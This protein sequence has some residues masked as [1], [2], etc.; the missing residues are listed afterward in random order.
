MR[1]GATIIGPGNVGT[2][3]AMKLMKEGLPYEMVFNSYDSYVNAA[4]N[5][6][7]TDHI[8]KMGN[9]SFHYDYIIISVQDNLIEKAAKLLVEKR[10]N[11]IKDKIIFHTSG[12]STKHQLSI[13]EDNGAKIAA[14]HPYQTFYYS[15]PKILDDIAWGVEADDEIFEKVKELIKSLSGRAIKLPDNTIENKH[16]YHASAVAAS[17]Y[18][19]FCIDLAKKLAKEADINPSEF[20]SQILRVTIENNI[21]KLEDD[22]PA[23]TGPIIREDFD[24]VENHIKAL[25]NRPDLQDSYKKLAEALADS[26][27]EQ[28]LMDEFVYEK[29][30]KVIKEES[31]K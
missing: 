10:P 6:I 30:K 27:K 26:A 24:T 13:L 21:K 14:A 7:P 4:N 28:N 12:S 9:A 15:D 22:S 11:I 16:I 1:F 2:T 25:K 29:M 8:V 3:L 18:L 5:G 23:L 19:T 31:D 20:M 17:N